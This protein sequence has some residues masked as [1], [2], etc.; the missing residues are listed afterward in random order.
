ME[1]S[2][3]KKTLLHCQLNMRASAFAFLY[4]VL[5]QDVPIATARAEMN[6]IWEPDGAWRE[7]ID[8]LLAMHDRSPR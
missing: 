3:A 6:E 7:L 4:R 8:E 5:Y 2:P 1:Q